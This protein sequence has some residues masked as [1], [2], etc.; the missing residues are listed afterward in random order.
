MTMSQSAQPSRPYDRPDWRVV[1]RAATVE[2]EGASLWLVKPAAES[3]TLSLWRQSGE[4][5]DVAVC[6]E[7]SGVV[8]GCAKPLKLRCDDQMWRLRRLPL[9]KACAL[10]ACLD[11]AS[12]EH[13]PVPTQR[14]PLGGFPTTHDASAQP[15]GAGVGGADRALPRDMPPPTRWTAV[16]RPAFV[17]CAADATNFRQFERW[18][19]RGQLE[20]DIRQSALFDF[21]RR[22]EAYKLMGFLLQQGIGAASTRMLGERYGLSETHFRR[23]C[24]TMLG[25]SLKTELRRWRAVNALFEIVNGRGTMTHI[26]MR[27]GYATPSHLSRE[28]REFFGGSPTQLRLA[29]ARQLGHA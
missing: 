16:G 22:E 14:P 23:L 19:I 24:R 12:A 18:L 1:R 10:L 2:L 20:R 15:D 26:A 4:T 13:A 8:L 7:A 28:I 3:A 17:V 5:T 9:R 6:N 25:R 27:G 11:G 21:F 29:S